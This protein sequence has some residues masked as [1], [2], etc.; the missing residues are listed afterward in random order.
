MAPKSRSASRSNPRPPVPKKD[1][2]VPVLAKQPDKSDHISKVVTTAKPGPAKKEFL[3]LAVE[4][5]SKTTVDVFH[6]KSCA[7]LKV[8]IMI[9]LLY[10]LKL[11]I[12]MQAPKNGGYVHHLKLQASDPFSLFKTI[13]IED[14]PYKNCQAILIQKTSWEFPLMKLPEE[15]RLMVYRHY[16]DGDIA[17]DAKR[18][19]NH[20]VYAKKYTAGS[21]NRVALFV[22]NKAISQ[23]AVQV[24]YEKTITFET[25]AHLLEFMSQVSPAVRN[26]L[27]RIKIKNYNRSTARTAFNLL[28]DAENIE[29]V[30]IENGIAN[31]GDIKKAARQFH[32]DTAKFLEAMVV[33]KGKKEAEL[34][35]VF[36]LGK[37]ALAI[38]DGSKIRPWAPDK[39]KEFEN[40]VLA[41]IK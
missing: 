38:K 41:K 10:R 12:S 33:R 36:V 9:C 18:S 5:D 27:H 1:S 35:N 2:V 29:T 34:C 25:S 15:A 3:K 37:H 6:E 32:S 11:T 21:R 19:S 23:V 28:V 22:A 8:S 20:E 16:L 39:V 4:K 26:R 31:D 40:G 24:L 17:I 30:T 14:G 7:A 13:V